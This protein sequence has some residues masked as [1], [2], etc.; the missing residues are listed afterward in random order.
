MKKMNKKLLQEKF[1]QKIA[2][3]L[4]FSNL[5]WSMDPQKPSQTDGVTKQDTPLFFTE[6][7]DMMTAAQ[8]EFFYK[9]SVDSE[10][11]F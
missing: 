7:G 4:L 10:C 8:W 3:L 9:S 6:T 1:M 2:L 11:D 5:I